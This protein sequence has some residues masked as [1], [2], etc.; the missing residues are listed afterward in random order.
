MRTWIVVAVA[1]V[2]PRAG[3]AQLW[4]VFRP[5]TRPEVADSVQVYR[6]LQG[7]ITRPAVRGD[8]VRGLASA[9]A[10]AAGAAIATQLAAYERAL[11]ALPRRWALRPTVT[12]PAVRLVR[13]ARAG[14]ELDAQLLSSVGGGVTF[15]S[16][17]WEQPATGDGRYVADLTWSPA[18]VLFTGRT[19]GGTTTLD[20]AWATG[21]GFFD[22][23]IQVGAGYNFG[24]V[25][26]RQRVFGLLSVGINFNQ[27]Q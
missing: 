25:A 24:A 7:A 11:A 13:S 9:D 22:N 20:V 23:R 26:A 3:E 12:I 21:V 5:L 1:L 6:T 19:E 16:L 8:S 18:T 14:A 17:R 15:E 2:L 4:G 27:V 10:R